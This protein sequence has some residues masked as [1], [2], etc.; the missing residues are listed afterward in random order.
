MKST[1]VQSTDQYKRG[2]N[3]INILL[4]YSFIIL[5]IA[6]KIMLVPIR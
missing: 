2:L 3:N 1:H 6:T 5:N 4:L